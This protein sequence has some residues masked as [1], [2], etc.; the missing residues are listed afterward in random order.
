[1]YWK[2]SAKDEN[3]VLKKCDELTIPEGEVLSEEGKVCRHVWFIKKGL[4]AAY[5]Q[6]PEDPTKEYCNW[7]MKENDIATSVLSF[8]LEGPSEE[9]I[10]A[11]EDT[12]VFRMSKKDLFAGIEQFPGML[13]LT[14]LIIIKYYCESKF[15]ETYLRMKQPQFIFK[16]MLTENHEVLQRAL[17]RD[18][19]TFLGVSEPIYRDI[20][21]GKYKPKQGNE[22]PDKPAKSNKKQ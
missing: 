22:K 3:Y 21:S 20:K 19:A 1:M 12:I 14:T 10:V 11:I 15:N 4:L 9:K 18:I 8:F 17:Q 16:H 2:L 7:F 5:Q 6:D 13:M